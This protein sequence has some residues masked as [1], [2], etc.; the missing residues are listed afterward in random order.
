MLKQRRTKPQLSGRYRPA[1]ASRPYPQSLEDDRWIVYCGNVRIS[2]RCAI[3]TMPTSWRARRHILRR[4]VATMITT[5]GRRN[6]DENAGGN[7][8]HA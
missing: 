2:R 5:T 3:G 8:K 1:S 6:T 7:L 4:P